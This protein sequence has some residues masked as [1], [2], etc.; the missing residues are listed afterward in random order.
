MEDGR[1]GECSLLSKGPC[2]FPGQQVSS[3]PVGS[4]RVMAG[5]APGA[6]LCS[7]CGLGLLPQGQLPLPVGPNKLSLS[8]QPCSSLV[9]DWLM[10]SSRE[11]PH[12]Q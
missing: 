4:Q 3:P 2:L 8:T 6:P 10:A 1:R 12:H 7:R 9:V 11:T 5:S